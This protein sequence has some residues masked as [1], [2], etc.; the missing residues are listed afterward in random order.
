MSFTTLNQL[1]QN[2]DNNIAANSWQG[3]TNIFSTLVQNTG[4]GN[5]IDPFQNPDGLYWNYIFNFLRNSRFYHEK[6]TFT[7]LFLDHYLFLQRK[8]RKRIHKGTPL[9]YLGLSYFDL[10]QIEQS[11]KYHMLA[12]TEDVIRYLQTQGRPTNP[13]TNLISTP[14]SIILEKRFRSSLNDL[15][16]L[17]NYV[18]SKVVAPFPF[19]PEE[20]YLE[21]IREV[22]QKSIL[23]ARSREEQLYKPNLEYLKTLRKQAFS[24]ATGKALELFAFYLFSCVDGFEPIFRKTTASFHFDVVVRNLIIDH[25]LLKNLGDYIGVEC[26]NTDNVNVSQVDHFILKL[27][28]HNMKCGI[29]FTRKRVTGAN[30]TYS[31]AV[32]EKIFQRDGII[33]FTITK[34]DINKIIDGCNFLSMLLKKYEDTRFT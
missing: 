10:N 22:E 5:L 28:L 9:Q 13:L 23:I 17:Q 4:K 30:G 12:F 26:K 34:T 11:R 27:R 18:L 29:I 21:W 24:D 33:I 32:I 2:L 31:K 20:I 16:E 19:N 25:P 1:K 7:Q 6:L 3:I 14:A 15:L 8:H